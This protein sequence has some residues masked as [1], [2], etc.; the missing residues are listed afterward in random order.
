M[1]L[2]MKT[3]T[4]STT[5]MAA[6]VDRVIKVKNMQLPLKLALEQLPIPASIFPLC[7]QKQK[8]HNKLCKG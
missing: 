6:G 8:A 2:F 5:G 4:N 7:V 3:L 1:H